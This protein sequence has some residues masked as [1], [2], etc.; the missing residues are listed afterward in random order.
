MDLASRAT[1]R[2][3]VTK[4]VNGAGDFLKSNECQIKDGM[5]QYALDCIEEEL[6]V[7]LDRLTSAHASLRK[8]NADVRSSIKTDDFDREA[9]SV[10]EYDD[11]A[12]S[13]IT[14]LQIR[15][16][17]VKQYQ[18][19][20]LSPSVPII[21]GSPNND[22]N[23]SSHN[24]TISLQNKMPAVKLQRLQ[25]KKFSGDYKEWIPFWE[26]YKTL[27]HDNLSLSTVD[28]FNYLEAALTGKAANTLV[29]LT[30]SELNYETAINILKEEYGNKEKIVDH[31]MQCLLSI[32]P[33][34]SKVDATGL[35]CLYNSVIA[36]TRSLA[37][38][39][40]PSSNYYVMLKGVLLRCIPNELRVDFHRYYDDSSCLEGDKNDI[41]DHN[42][43]EV[44]SIRSDISSTKDI[45]DKTVKYLL[46]FIKREAESLEKAQEAKQS[47]T[48]VQSSTSKP[49]KTAVGLFTAGINDNHC[50]FCK[51]SDHYSSDC[52]SSFPI[53]KKKQM[54][55]EDGRCFRCC[56][57]GH[58]SKMCKKRF[59]LLCKIC[60]GRHATS[61]CDPNHTQSTSTSSGK[62]KSTPPSPS[63]Q[64]NTLTSPI[65][66]QQSTNLYTTQTQSHNLVQQVNTVYLQTAFA[67]ASKKNSCKSLYVRMVLDG[68]SQMSFIKSSVARQLDL[69]IIGIQ[70]INIIPFGSKEPRPS[71][72][73]NKVQVVLRNQYDNRI[74]SLELMEVPE[75]CVDVLSTPDENLETL[76]DLQLADV[77]LEN[78]HAENGISILI[79]ADNYWVVATGQH[80]RITPDLTAINTV[81]GWTLQGRSP[82]ISHN[83]DAVL[84]LS[85]V[86]SLH[87]CACED[88]QQF[89]RLETIGITNDKIIERPIEPIIRKVADRY[90]AS[91][92]W[93]D[94]KES[95]HDN[96]IGALYRMHSLVRKLRAIGRLKDYESSMQEMING[97]L[98]ERVKD[99]G[100]AS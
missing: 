26:Q 74:V 33:V 76:S 61:M 6:S 52:K 86:T 19:Q 44:S 85:C 70:N 23:I 82:V 65:Q 67:F 29:G 100:Y 60:N 9:E 68:G 79:G 58:Y 53:A 72:Q 43:N 63:T 31:N 88:L 39:G 30:P 35:R 96:R 8:A 41:S 78:L 27:V 3:Q 40:I 94:V 4:I 38:L 62:K 91:L 22:N 15:L 48:R 18:K 32:Q 11:K 54:L 83:S 77:R 56:R 66:P 17:K 89:W 55:K 37:A 45:G 16:N 92:P 50:F 93:R 42:D 14:R 64:N 47:S 59:Q 81:L 28:K 36:S 51:A 2:G 80:K 71:M 5:D 49:V 10:A 46:K 1:F 12:V 75:I 21:D 87:V 97:G 20:L 95:L 13:T 34:Q 25:P 98:A 69:D 73:C 57:K 99:E 24:A 7:F 90:E 84:N